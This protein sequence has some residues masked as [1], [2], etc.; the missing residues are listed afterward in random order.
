MSKWTMDVCL[1]FRGQSWSVRELDAVSIQFVSEATS[2]DDISE[3]MSVGGE[4]VLVDWLLGHS[5]GWL[6]RS[7]SQG[8]R[9]VMTRKV[10][11]ESSMAPR[12]SVLVSLVDIAMHPRPAAY[13][14]QQCVLH[15]CGG[16][17]SGIRVRA[18]LGSADSSLL[19]CRPPASPCVPACLKECGGSLGVSFVRALIPFVRAFPSR[20]NP[21]PRAPSSNTV[22]LGG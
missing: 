15:R 8:D 12:P 9:G 7:S 10:G 19:G 21:F 4:G 5:R 6:T 16:R 17:N 2:V 18:C 22:T 11:Q 20:P 13:Q 14:E 1:G 3:R